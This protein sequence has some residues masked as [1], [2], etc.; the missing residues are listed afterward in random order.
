[1]PP[2]SAT[3]T[4]A[5]SDDGKEKDKKKKNRCQQCSSK[6]SA[7]NYFQCRCSD[8]AMFCASHR[9]PSDHACTYDHRSRQKASLTKSNPT[10]K[11]D[12]L[13]DRL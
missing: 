10:V 1:V 4:P 8:V 7:V 12:K 6:L 13:S 5:A 3:A 2:A 9:L 11:G